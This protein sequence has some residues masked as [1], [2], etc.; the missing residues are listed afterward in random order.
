MSW[1]KRKL[2]VLGKRK[3]TERRLPKQVSLSQV[4]QLESRLCLGS[5]NAPNV[6]DWTPD[7]P[8]DP[9]EPIAV[10]TD[11]TLTDTTQMEPDGTSI[12]TLEES[13][14]TGTSQSN[15]TQ[16]GTTTGVSTPNSLDVGLD[17]N[18]TQ[19]QWGESETGSTD[20]G[21][22]LP[23]ETTGTE[24]DQQSGDSQALGVVS[25]T[26][27]GS[28]GEAGPDGGQQEDINTSEDATN[29]YVGDLSG[30]GET[31]EVH[32]PPW[33]EGMEEPVTIKYDFRDV[34]EFE[35]YISDAQKALAVDALETWSQASGGMVQFEQDSQAADHE[36]MNIGTGELEAY[37][38]ASGEGGKLGLGGGAVSRDDTGEVVVA[39]TAWMDVTENWDESIGNGDPTDTVDFHTVVGHEIGHVLGFNDSYVYHTGEQ[40]IMRGY[41]DAERGTD[42]YATAVRE[43][44]MYTGVIDQAPED[45]SYEMR[46]MAM[47]QLTPAEVTILLQRASAAT[48]SDDAV[49][50]VVDRGGTILG[51]HVEAGVIANIVDPTNQELARA[52]GG[53]GDGGVIDTDIERRAL[54]FFAEGA[55]AK[56]RTAAFFSNGDPTNISEESPLGTRAPLTSRLV[57]FISQTTITQREVES[58]SALNANANYR[59]PGF[60]APIGLGGHF[61]PEVRH[62]PPVD[63]FAIEH[64]NRDRVAG[65]VVV[66][67][68]ANF[69]ANFDN[70][71][72]PNF[73]ATQNTRFVQNPNP[74][75]P[76][77]LRR[78]NPN[79][80]PNTPANQVQP[81]DV[82]RFNIPAEFVGMNM[83]DALREPLSFGEV[84]GLDPNARSR[85]IATL[86]GG[87]PIFRDVAAGP[88]GTDAG[89]GDTLIGGIGVFFPGRDGFATFEQ[90][91]KPGVEQ[92]EFERTNAPK[93]LEAEFM[94]LVAIGGSLGAARVGIPGANVKGAG[95][96]FATTAFAAIPD[97][98]LP[99]GRLDL[100]GI[101]LQVIGPEASR[102]GVGE[103]ILRGLNIGIGTPSGSQVYAPN[104]M[105][106]EVPFGYVVPPRAAADGSL[107]AAQVDQIIQNAIRGANE[108]RAAVRLPVSSRTRMVFAV[109]DL[110]GNILGLFRMQDATVFSIDVAV[111]KA[112]N[113]AYYANAAEL[114]VRDQVP[115]IPAGTAFTN[116]TFRFLAEPRFPSGVDGDP[117]GPF[118]TL[119]NPFIDP[120]TGRNTGTPAADTNY[121]DT[122]LGRNA[123]NPT[124]PGVASNR[125][126]LDPDDLNNQNGVVFFPGS[127]PL[128]ANGRLV[129]GFGVSGDGVDQDDVVT[130]I[131]A[132][133]F[134]PQQNGVA[135]SDQTHFR[136]V[137]LPYQK[138]LRNPFG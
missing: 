30:Y 114:D 26:V 54:A 127:T 101:S 113:T 33:W 27:V 57:R 88:G 17:A 19:V 7:D 105:G 36:I 122:V 45:A 47:A 14:D 120:F 112:R 125:N 61:P 118:S 31:Q 43:G 29:A 70:A 92:A 119:N 123:F 55:V 32:L 60:V 46:A 137:R 2:D 93:V 107:T 133:G 128:Y 42:A 94:A 83:Q 37:G 62:T 58:V 34:G 72:V 134:L 49:I 74:M 3:G 102:Q 82:L 138:F 116:R 56:A 97:I 6:G 35:N 76:N 91:F 24:T 13:Q 90:G 25:N 18:Q 129:G 103:V 104:V 69:G 98:D 124:A 16:T 106:R 51:V 80:D 115:T 28:S 135:R 81:T 53:T 126:F 73:M 63:L 1:L 131:G 78:V 121:L 5:L 40:N 67:A 130:F 21:N 65:D 23:G 86:P 109:S 79:Q 20:G 64:T 117:A 108:V 15:Q 100:V 41:Y 4:E 110:D 22:N 12:P 38:Y 52:F 68:N 71:V 84:S 77:V 50:A 136:D 75:G 8:N 85:G 66:P 9:L 132:Q 89:V 11:Q 10:S 96:P 48:V 44:T 87:I 59:G 39:G 111:A 95:D 99:F